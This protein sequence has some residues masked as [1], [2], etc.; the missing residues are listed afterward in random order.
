[1]DTA[2]IIVAKKILNKKLKIINKFD[3]LE[4]NVEKINSERKKKLEES[5]EE[6]EKKIKIAHLKI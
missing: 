1:M 4:K 2:K 5:R 3:K 6:E